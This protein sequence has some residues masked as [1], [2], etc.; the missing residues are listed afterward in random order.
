LAAG[1]V[2]VTVAESV[3]VLAAVSAAVWVAES[4]VD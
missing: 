3:V 4:V 1:W 2:A